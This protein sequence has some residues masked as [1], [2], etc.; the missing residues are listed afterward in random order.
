[1]TGLNAAGTD[2]GTPLRKRLR[3]LVGIAV[4]SLAAT[5]LVAG[6]TVPADPAEAAAPGPK[7]V[8]AVLFEYTWNAIARE[9][10]EN[11]G[12]AGYGYVQTSPPQEHVQGPQWWIHYQPVSYRVE[13]RLGTRAEFKAMVDTCHAAGVKVIADAVINHMSGD[14]DGGVGWAGSAYQH[15]DY[16]GTYQSQD[17]HSCRR[18]IANYQDRWEVQECNLVNLAD[19]NTGS[20]YVQGRIAAYLNDLVSLGVDGFRIDAV[21]HIAATDMQGILSRVNDRARMY[22]VQEVIRA[23]EPIQPEEY[24]SLGDIHEFAF[25]RKLKEAFGGRT[26][27]WL[28][29]G[30][31]IGPTWSGFLPNAN[32]AVFVDNHDTER[33]GET[34]NYKDGAA[35]D[36][37]QVFT[38][39]WNY[40]SPSVHSGYAFSN[41]DAGPALAGNGEVVDAVCGQNGWTCTHARTAI[42]NMVGFRTATYGTAITDKWDNGSSAIAFGRA[43]KGFVAINRGTAAID[44]TWQTSLPAGQYCNVIAGLPTASGCSAGGV[45]TVDSSGRFTASVGAD[46]ALALHAGAKAGGSGTTPPPSGSTMTVYYASTKGWTN[47]YVHYRVGS[48]TWTTVPGAQMGAACTGWVSKIID[49]GSATGITAAFN[50]GSGSWD[51]NGGADYAL[52]GPVAAVNNGV[53]SS[54]NPCAAQPTTTTVYYA[55]GWSTANIH[56]QVGSGS[57][58]AVPGVAMANACAGWKVRTID[59][60]GA[61]GVT[62][63]FNNGS[64]SWD[65]NGGKD[66]AIGAGVMKVQNGTVSAGN[67]CS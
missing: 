63:A 2:R 31:G 36:L 18:D 54:T 22:V 7:D 34:L 32:A 28:I 38:L 59:L 11:L 55:T 66:Y 16:P 46:T 12:P 65:N 60:G 43:D 64:G 48:G 21:K 37:A 5:I 15:Y 45:I 3:A 44:R 42:E 26:L 6:P 49:L 4:A 50:N 13:S 57:W 40:G 30:S 1:M 24:T 19:L 25:A 29:S 47:H 8:T 27:N 53:V 14:S 51:N 35:Y 20:S 10:T 67:P 17:F 62:A 56:Y 33:N 58:T 23:N 9:C 39:A 61:T 52:A 41:T